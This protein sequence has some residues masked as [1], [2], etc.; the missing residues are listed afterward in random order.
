[1]DGKPGTSIFLKWTIKRLILLLVAIFVLIQIAG[2]TLGYLYLSSVLEENQNILRETNEGHEIINE[3]DK[4]TTHLV[5]NHL[6]LLE[7]AQKLHQTT[8]QTK[9]EILRFVIQDAEDSEQLKKAHDSLVS[10]FSEVKNLWS[11]D[12]P[13]DIL[14]RMK[15][16]LLIMNDI[17][18]EAIEIT[19]P[20]IL[21]ELE[22]DARTSGNDIQDAASKLMTAIHAAVGKASHE[23]N[24]H[25]HQVKQSIEMSKRAA[26]SSAAKT[27][28][29]I[30]SGTTFI[31]LII[32]ALFAVAV[33]MI[34]AVIHPIEKILHAVANLSEGEGD[35][36]QRLEV[37]GSH[38]LSQL[39]GAFNNFIARVDDMVSRMTYSVVRLIPMAQ[40]LSSTNA[41]ILQSADEQKRQ[42]QAVAIHMQETIKSAEEVADSVENISAIANS[43][44]AKLDEGQQVAH[45]TID[46]IDQLAKE[47][48]TA[49]N[50]VSMLITDSEKI[51]SVIDVINSISE[52]TNLL[53]LNAAI[54]AARA[55][56]AGRGFAVV[57]DEVRNLAFRTRE[58]TLEVQS[59]IQS[60]Q[61]NT[62]SVASAMDLGVTS[63]SNSIGLVNKTADAIREVGQLIGEINIRAGEIK[64]ATLQQNESFRSVSQSISTIEDYSRRSI[65]E[66]D[67]NFEFGRDLHKLNDKLQTMVKAFKVTDSEWSEQLRSK[68]RSDD[69]LKEQGPEIW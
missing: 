65:S 14:E 37:K 38:E 13:V 60:I 42:T 31:T 36:T 15:A 44:V 10:T 50:A 51:E 3:L 12:L 4:E 27:K 56:E 54:E 40:E 24:Q 28:A 21:A 68:K 53:A 55:G 5:E 45:I 49:H 29:M 57:A 41:N 23:I 43:S 67:D 7:A 46:A 19:S 33:L 39:A 17:V 63:T 59:M 18:S 62:R 64:T 25:S 16:N 58:S 1:M 6:P 66:L 52:Q 8:G 61:D 69:A 35:L 30:S 2:N 26:E 9:H 11:D 32:L 47:I 20:P 34:K 22:E 48:T